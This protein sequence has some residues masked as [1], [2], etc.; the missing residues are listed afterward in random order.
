M[1]EGSPQPAPP[2][3]PKVGDEIDEQ[4]FGPFDRT[5]LA[6]YA[7]VSGDDNPLHLDPDVAKAV[8]LAAPPVHGMLMLSCFEPAL[9]AWRPDLFIAGLSAKFLRPVLAGEAIRISGRVVR[10]QDLPTP[11][12]MLRMIARGPNQDLA[13]LGEATVL[14]K[15]LAPR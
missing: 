8:G 12:L 14:P 1:I 4:S 3:W 13:I 10:R 7:E 15:T 6:R 2:D 5:A 9:R 11:K